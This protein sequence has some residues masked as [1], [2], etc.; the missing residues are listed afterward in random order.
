M[1]K[2]GSWKQVELKDATIFSLTTQIKNLDNKISHTTTSLGSG[3]SHRKKNSKFMLKDWR[4]KFKGKEKA[5]DGVLWYWCSKYIMEGVYNTMYA[6]HPEDK[7]YEWLKRK[8]VLK[9]EKRDNE[10]SSN[11]QTTDAV[12]TLKL[13]LSN[14]LNAAMVANFHC[15]EAEANDL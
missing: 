5:V 13:T 10:A 8:K 2:Q 9:R 12:K 4:I 6:R 3:S 11:S 14:N 7:H 1:G 15:S